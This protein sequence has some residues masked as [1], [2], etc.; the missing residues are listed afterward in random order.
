MEM[1][2]AVEDETIK[3]CFL[4]SVFVMSESRSLEC[5][6]APEVRTQITNPLKIS[7]G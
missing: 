2:N 7:I 4:G 6:R 1:I 5:E 3:E